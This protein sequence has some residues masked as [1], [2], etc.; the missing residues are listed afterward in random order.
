MAFPYT[1]YQALICDG[2]VRSGKTSFMACSFI[3]WS[4]SNYNNQTFIIGGKSIESVVR[5]VI[6][7]LQSLAWARKRYTMSYSSYTHEL[8]VRRGKVKNVYVVFGGKDA[9]SYELVQGFT[10]AGA[11]IDEVVLCV[12]SFV[13]QCLARC[14]VQGARFFFN[15]NPA[16]PTHWF[17]KEWIDKAS[18]H[19][20]LY[21]KFTLR[22]NPSLTEDTLRRYET[23]YSG[24]FHQRYI[25]G[26]WVAAEGVVYDCFD[27]ST[28]CRDIDVDGSDVVYCSIDYGITN[29]FAALLW[30]VRNG[31][32]YCFREYRYDS[33]EEQR[34][35]TDEEHWANVK[36]MFK[37][38]W[39]DEVIVDPSAS[40]LIELIRKEGFYNVLGAK[41][42]V[43]SGIQ[44]VTTLMNTH[45]LIISPSCTGLLSELGVYSWQGK[46]D[47]V[48]KENDHSCDAMRYFIETIGINLLDMN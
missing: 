29:P 44:H 8:T 38:L 35:L 6:K 40:S 46:G 30:V 14:S 45:K 3:N 1:D 27:K 37:G 24:V 39:V 17:K 7:P 9:A 12:R 36:A 23:M 42:D 22:D 13:E 31:V 21:L 18:E 2:A 28:M 43:L 5:N 47:T 16:S 15:C 32:A 20:A 10:A 4:M 41:N 11:L 25:L 48:I 33:K 34:R 19:N 26:D